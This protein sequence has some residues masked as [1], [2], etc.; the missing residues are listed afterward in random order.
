MIRSSE[1]FDV[2]EAKPF[3][4][5]T[6]YETK[7]QSL[8]LTAGRTRSIAISLSISAASDNSLELLGS[9]RFPLELQSVESGARK[10]SVHWRTDCGLA[11]TAQLI[12][13]AARSIRLAAANPSSK[14]QGRMDA[15][16][17]NHLYP[18]SA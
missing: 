3:L 18:Y 9:V 4:R 15:A 5:W 7:N 6:E 17:R 13:L 8:Y 12:R 2:C 14:A 1:S 11:V 16:P 10:T